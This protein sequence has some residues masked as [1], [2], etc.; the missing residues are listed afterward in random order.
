MKRLFKLT[1]CAF[2]SACISLPAM[3]DEN[4]KLWYKAPARQWVEALPVG[5]GSMGAM[6][7]GGIENEQLQLNEETVW[8]GGPHQNN[9]VGL[10]A[11]LSKI[12]NLVFQ[13]KNEEAQRLLDPFTNA[14]DNGMPYQTI[15]S[16]FFAFEGV[17][18]ASNYRREL[19]L[20]RAVHTT[21]FQ[22]DGYH[23]KREVFASFSDHV[24]VMRVTTDRPAGISANL[25]F[26][27]PLLERTLC[28]GN[29]VLVLKGK[30]NSHEGIEGKIN[31][32][33]RVEAVTDGG[34]T[35]CTD[36]NLSVCGA[37]SVTFYIAAGTNFVNYRDVSGNATEKSKQL[38]SQAL[39]TPYDEALS[40]H[41]RIYRTYFDRVSFTMPQSSGSAQDTRSRLRDFNKG[42]D[43]AFVPLMFQYGRYLLISSSQPGGQPANLQGI[44]NKDTF[45]PWDGKY[46]TDI[47]LQMNY[48]PAEVTNLSEMAEPL[49]S[50]IGRLAVQGT[51]T[52]K[53]MYGARGWVQHHNTDIWCCTGPVDGAYFAFWPNGGGWLSTHLW[54]HYLY[55]GDKNYLKQVYGILKG[56][57]D[58]YLSFLVKHPT[59]HW[60]VMCPSNSPE[61]GWNASSVCAG[62]TMD[63]Q[64]AFDVLTQAQAAA[65]IL[66]RDSQFQD[67]CAKIVAQLPP[68]QIGQHKQLQ[69]WLEDKDNPWDKHRH[70]SHLYGFFPG[71]QI[72]AYHTPELFAAAINS[73][74]QRG[75]EATGWSIGWKINL[76]ARALQG[77]H[78]YTIIKNMLKLLPGDDMTSLYPEG[79]TYPNLFDAHPPFQ[80]DG[81]F[82][83]TSGVAEMLMQS[84]DGAVQLLP[85]LPAEWKS[86]QIKGLRA[87][88]GFDVD[89]KW[90]D[91]QLQRVVV[92]SRL[93][94]QLRIRSYV[95]LQG[96]GLTKAQGS[97]SNPFYRLPDVK[98]PLKNAKV[99]TLRPELR[100][101]Y[102]YDVQTQAGEVYTFEQQK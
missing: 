68:M 28:D 61:H 20:N 12:R 26:T 88:G 3:A 55:S 51:E 5:C 93:G 74:I 8:G 1:I 11:Q 60:M 87:R 63:N 38:L 14:T 72:S 83:F 42:E 19:D 73:L 45:A 24:I 96:T 41:E 89:L 80:I 49:F 97:N 75:D 47:N 81:N 9:P 99:G 18:R 66:G 54:E 53:Q 4:L 30:C 59:N 40:A 34:Q 44:W 78:A 7:Y 10:P 52:A 92:K 85:A 15:G 101:V 102:E 77:D 69:E 33:C 39:Q 31:F 64:I 35:T 91:A 43:V 23:Y 82:G 46:T 94:G 95:P 2:L 21:T 76:W 57:A 37:N 48:W 84:H 36:Q 29:R 50:L 90:N 16:L 58:F 56:A 22:V 100:T 13:G 67:S 17:E 62:C 70:M 25:H 65:K 86:G 71:R 98:S 79:R 27:S 32:D 6:V